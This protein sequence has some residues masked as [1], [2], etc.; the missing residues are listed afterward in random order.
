MRK[1]FDPTVKVPHDGQ[2]LEVIFI[3]RQ[4]T[5]YVFNDAC[6]AKSAR[7]GGVEPEKNW[8]FVSNKAALV[9]V[10]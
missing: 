7:D 1:H 9:L 6:D 10:K 4:E 8:A 5:F 3:D 2:G